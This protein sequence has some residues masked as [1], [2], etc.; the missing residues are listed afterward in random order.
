MT[1]GNQNAGNEYARF[2]GDGAARP[3]VER[4]AVTVRQDGRS[5][6]LFHG[7]AFEIVCL[8][9]VLFL[10]GT[11]YKVSRFHPNPVPHAK[12]RLANCWVVPRTNEQA[13]ARVAHLQTTQAQGNY[14]AAA[15][16][17]G[18]EDSARWPVRTVATAAPIISW[19]GT[20][21]PG[22]SPPSI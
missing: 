15:T 19:Q 22:R 12:M 3:E 9:F 1:A 8:A 10:W 6:S 17:T 13:L 21:I 7:R 2:V 11:S 20:R 18:I 5:E 4:R 14:A 16:G